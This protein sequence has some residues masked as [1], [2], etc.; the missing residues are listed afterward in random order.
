MTK[1]QQLLTVGIES[2][3]YLLLSSVTRVLMPD[4]VPFED[5]KIFVEVVQSGAGNYTVT[6]WPSNVRWVGNQQPTVAV[7]DS[8]TTVLSFLT[9]DRGASWIGEGRS[10]TQPDSVLGDINA[11]LEAILQ[12]ET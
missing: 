12:P 4:N 11:A 9:F 10:I 2:D 3:T 6:G 5:Y 7:G 1:V 8:A